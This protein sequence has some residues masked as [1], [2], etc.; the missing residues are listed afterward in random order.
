MKRFFLAASVLVALTVAP[1]AARAQ[2]G[3][4]RGKVVDEQGQGV[5]DAKIQVEF[6][7]GVTRKLETTTN[8]K[9][10]FTQ[11]GLQPGVY[12]FTVNKDGFQG[13]FLEAKVA[14][15]DPTYLPDI[16]IAKRGP[17]GAGGGSAAGLGEVKAAVEKAIELTKAGKLDEAEAAYRDLIAK[18]PQLAVLHHNLAIIQ[19][20]KKDNAAAE[21]EYLKAIEV[22]PD[23]AESYAA[24]SNLYL[25]TGKAD[26]A[27]DLVTKGVAANP[28]NAK[29]QLNLGIV[30]FNAGKTDEA[31]A[32]VKK[33]ASLDASLAEAHFYLG[34]IAVQQGK[35]DECIA[36]LEKYLASSPT[37]QQNVQT[38]QGLLAALKKK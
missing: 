17:G 23:Y 1:A 10:E 32:A 11:V 36:E 19:T 30:Y 7:G 37:N 38:A 25:A 4:A 34:N 33:A 5:P 20:A 18:N 12:K 15:G 3:T 21:A 27:V 28:D 35:T 16:K 29:L 6:Q 31:A 13:T 24:L 22:Q 8:K 26:K 9:G 2:T 14:L